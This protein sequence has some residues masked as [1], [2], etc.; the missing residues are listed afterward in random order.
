[1]LKCGETSKKASKKTNNSIKKRINIRGKQI[2]ENVEKEILDQMDINS[3]NTCFIT[4]KDHKDNF[5]NN[6][7]VRLIN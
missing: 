2:M 4:L 3:K 7:T 5:L 1:M 6:P